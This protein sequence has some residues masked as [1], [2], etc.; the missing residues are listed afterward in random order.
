[1]RVVI[2]GFGEKIATEKN[3]GIVKR[4]KVDAGLIRNVRKI[5]I[6]DC[7]IRLTEHTKT[8]TPK[9]IAVS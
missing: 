9:Y 4:K 7:H 5:M 8:Q 2:N 1:M 6:S 3:Y